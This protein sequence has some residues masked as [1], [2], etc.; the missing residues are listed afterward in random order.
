MTLR[1]LFALAL[2]AAAGGVTLS[3]S[4]QRQEVLLQDEETSPPAA[5]LAEDD[6]PG[7]LAMQL[8]HSSGEALV[9]STAVGTL[10]QALQS[11]ELDGNPSERLD[12]ILKL[13]DQ[14]TSESWLASGPEALQALK[15]KFFKR[16][17]LKAK[18][19]LM[20]HLDGDCSFQQG[21]LL[22]C[23]A[24]QLAASQEKLGDLA[25]L[26]K[27]INAT[28]MS[29]RFYGVD[30]VTQS[31]LIARWDKEVEWVPRFMST[32][33]RVS[34]A[35][36]SLRQRINVTPDF[37]ELVKDTCAELSSIRPKCLDRASDGAFCQALGQAAAVNLG[38][39]E[40]S[41]RLGEVLMTI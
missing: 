24:L 7:P 2:P 36:K 12:A 27:L 37:R 14:L 25:T 22:F 8:G 6:A 29:T 23:E 11:G 35:F 40:A 33:S 9:R 4:G 20:C 31:A 28:T 41:R 21:S 1:R 18:V 3:L 39:L 32:V 30:T 19:Q 5:A 15:G 38:P 26:E 10:V 13:G 17:D 34:G 16:D